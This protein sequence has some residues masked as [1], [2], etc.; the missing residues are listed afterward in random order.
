M[1]VHI[2]TDLDVERQRKATPRSPRSFRN[3]SSTGPKLLC[4]AYSRSVSAYWPL[5]GSVGRGGCRSLHGGMRVYGLITYSS[6]E[7]CR[8]G[9]M[10]VCGPTMRSLRDAGVW[11]NNALEDGGMEGWRD[12][13]MDRFGDACVDQ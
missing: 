4:M 7:T 12:G 2:S 1:Y 5:E 13:G 10:R 3:Y 8:D 11:T 6:M 9:V